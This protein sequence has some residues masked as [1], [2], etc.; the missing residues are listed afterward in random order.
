[1]HHLCERDLQ[2]R[3]WDGNNVGSECHGSIKH[4]LPSHIYII[5]DI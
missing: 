5:S 3:Y 1:M 2:S 4:G